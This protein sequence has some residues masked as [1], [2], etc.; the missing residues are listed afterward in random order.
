M[1]NPFKD[2]DA[3]LTKGKGSEVQATVRKTWNNEVQVKTVDG[4]L[5]WRTIYTVWRA[6]E[7]PLKREPKAATAVPAEGHT[8][9]ARK[10]KSGSRK[11][12]QAASKSKP[13]KGK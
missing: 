6:G 13:R 7:A 4:D 9:T 11:T 3:V 8:A 10:P 2:G 12:K 5:L 1:Q